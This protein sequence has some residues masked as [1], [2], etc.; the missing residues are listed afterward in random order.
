MEHQ[1]LVLELACSSNLVLKL[2]ALPKLAEV[3][4]RTSCILVLGRIVRDVTFNNTSHSA[5]LD[6]K[7]LSRSIAPIQRL[8]IVAENV[9]AS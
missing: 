1:D 8:S 2:A 9:Y 4:A 5:E 6:A 7:V 3:K